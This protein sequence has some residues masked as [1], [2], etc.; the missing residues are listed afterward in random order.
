MKGGASYRRHTHFYVSRKVT[1]DGRHSIAR[2]ARGLS[3]I[4]PIC[5]AWRLPTQEMTAK[6]RAVWPIADY[7][8]ALC[9]HPAYKVRPRGQPH[10]RQLRKSFVDAP[11]LSDSVID[12]MFSK[13]QPTDVAIFGG[14]PVFDTVRS[15]S[16]LVQPNVERFLHYSKIFHDAGQYTDH[17]TVEREFERGSQNF[18]ML[19]TA[20]RLPGDSGG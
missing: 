14:P 16:N 15:I 18:T 6:S 9:C 10:S 11:A 8:Q 20:S 13:T 19:I 2:T 5:R 7:P 3:V 4:F 17:G 1:G 12:H